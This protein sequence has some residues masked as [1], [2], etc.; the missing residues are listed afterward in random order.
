MDQ[1]LKERLVGI[2]VLV[3]WIAPQARVVTADFL[4]STANWINP[5]DREQENPKNFVI[6][7]PFY[8]EKNK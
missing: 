5:K 4:R 2:I 1:Q 6:P 8:E 3:L 7:N